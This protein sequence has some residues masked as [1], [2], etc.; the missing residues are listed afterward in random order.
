MFT[1]SKFDNKQLRF[2]GLVNK[3]GQCYS[4]DI[5][6]GTINANGKLYTTNFGL[7]NI[8]LKPIFFR[9]VLKELKK[10][11]KTL[12]QYFLG[13]QAIDNEICINQ[14]CHGFC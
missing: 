7:N 1:G 8:V 6:T 10:D 5:E 11:P 13:F 2:F 12:V 4:I 9:G 3:E 14:I